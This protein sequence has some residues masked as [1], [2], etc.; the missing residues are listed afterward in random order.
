MKLLKELKEAAKRLAIYYDYT[1]AGRGP[2]MIAGPF[3]DM[4][5]AKKYAKEN[6]WS[7]KGDDYFIDEYREE[8]DR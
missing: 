1:G 5:Q 6:D 8:H 4:E 7:L 2:E 3:D